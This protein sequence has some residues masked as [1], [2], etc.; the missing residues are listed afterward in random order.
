MK[1]RSDGLTSSHERD[2]LPKPDGTATGLR[3]RSGDEGEG[4][5]IRSTSSHEDGRGNGVEM[6]PFAGQ[7]VRL[8]RSP[9]STLSLRQ[10]L[11]TLGFYPCPIVARRAS[12]TPI[13]PLGSN[14]QETS[15]R[16]YPVDSSIALTALIYPP[17]ISPRQGV[18]P[19]I[20]NF[21]YIYIHIY[22]ANYIPLYLL[23]MLRD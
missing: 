14:E 9:S 8:F 7:R 19:N 10:G 12:G 3:V 6:S 2:K 23:C 13:G 20:D 11:F 15:W 1:E 16:F 21:I 18:K 22:R 4:K 5:K 17:S